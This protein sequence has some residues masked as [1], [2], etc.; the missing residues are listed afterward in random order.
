MQNT[1]AVAVVVWAGG[2]MVAEAVDYQHAV[3]LWGAGRR[4]RRGRGWLVCSL[5]YMQM[6]W[7][8][9]SLVHM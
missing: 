4:S 7:P 1:P 9:K 5:G 8:I 6:R 2:I 3:L